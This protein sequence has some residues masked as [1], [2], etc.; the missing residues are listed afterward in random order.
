MGNKET[1]QEVTDQ[2]I[3]TLEDV[4][5]GEWERPWDPSVGLPSN[6]KTGK[7]Y[8]GVN[9]PL[10]WSYQ[11]S[12]NYDHSEWMT[13]KQAQ[14]EG[15]HVRRGES[16][17]KIVFYRIWEKETV[18]NLDT[19]DEV[20]MDIDVEEAE[21]DDDL[22]VETERIPVWRTHTVFNID[23]VEDVDPSVKTSDGDRLDEVEEVIENLDVEFQE[24][25]TRASY[26][27][28]KDTVSVPA[29]GAF[30]SDEDFYSTLFHELIHWTG[31]ESR[32][33]REYGSRFPAEKDEYAFEELVAEL[34]SSF[35]CAEYGIEKDMEDPAR[36][37]DRWLDIL[38]DDE[39]N[40]FLAS[41]KAQE[42][43]E[44]IMGMNDDN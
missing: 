26:N 37:I 22:K 21:E 30:N 25:S 44:F 17:N 29:L 3:E 42:A 13:Y 24:G 36:Y 35:L 32:L 41:Y 23:Q 33:D 20:D 43:T 15:G 39:Y 12:E 1:Y 19:G 7:N 38:E 4:E 16:G 6:R 11:Q 40:I 9:V 14:D 8:S 10:L 31:H 34:G 18:I 5:S 28:K 27:I 2:I